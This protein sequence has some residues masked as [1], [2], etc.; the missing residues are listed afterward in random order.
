[1][2]NSDSFI[3]HNFAGLRR[4]SRPSKASLVSFVGSDTV[5]PSPEYLSYGHR[6][7]VTE[8][9][10]PVRLLSTDHELLDAYSRTIT[11]V[12]GQVAEA[13]VHIQVQ[14]PANDRKNGPR[15]APG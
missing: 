1:M 9:E 4:T 2:E 12:V 14:T 6:P 11:S 7:S 8:N 10:S 13:V 5:E 15:L 3:D